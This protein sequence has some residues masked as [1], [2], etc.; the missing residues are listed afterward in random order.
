MKTLININRLGWSLDE[1]DIDAT[2]DIIQGGIT[3]NQYAE[4]VFNPQKHFANIFIEWLK[5]PP[6]KITRDILE[7]YVKMSPPELYIPFTLAQP[8]IIEQRIIAPLES[9]KRL[10]CSE[11]FLASIALSGLVGELLV[12]F[13]WELH[14][15]DRKPISDRNIIRN[16]FSELPQNQRLNMLQAFGYIN[17]SQTGRFKELY[18]RR[19]SMLHSWTD[20]FRRDEIETYAIRCYCNAAFL[21]KGIFGIELTTADSLKMNV[22]VMRYI[23]KLTS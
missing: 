7:R 16:G 4:T 1:R 21:M 10:A 23:K 12:I 18:Q 5:I 3:G 2:L 22:E 8:E 11:E 9:A 6:Q 15:D 19:N 17:D 13:Q 14:A 20:A